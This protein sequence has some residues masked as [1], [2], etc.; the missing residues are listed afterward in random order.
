MNRA[1]CSAKSKAACGWE[2]VLDRKYLYI[3]GGVAG[4][5]VI[6][7]LAWL[8]WPSGPATTVSESSGGSR[9]ELTAQDH[10][11][12]SANAPIQVVEYAAPVCPALRPFRHGCVPAL[13]GAI[14]RHRE[15]ALHAA[16]LSHPC[17]RRRGG[18]HGAMSATR[19]VLLLPRSD[20]P[21]PAQMGPGK[22]SRRYPWR[23][24]RYGQD[25]RHAAGPGG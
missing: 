1:G 18:R 12:G 3:G 5:V 17:R 24:G 2:A 22:R 19:P 15:S 11:L 14:H 23:P 21:Q 25:R 10:S 7:L 9:V 6:A 20:V 4:V 16:H 13:E 8:L